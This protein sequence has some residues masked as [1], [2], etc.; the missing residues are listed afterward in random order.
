MS[1]SQFYEREFLSNREQRLAKR[2]KTRTR[3]PHKVNVRL[4]RSMNAKLSMGRLSSRTQVE[5]KRGRGLCSGSG[6]TWN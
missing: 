1:E 5:V 4:S 2:G 3:D 6:W